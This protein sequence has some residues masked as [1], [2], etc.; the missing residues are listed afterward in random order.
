MTDQE[1]TPSPGIMSP[2]DVTAQAAAERADC[3]ATHPWFTKK[4]VTLPSAVFLLFVIIMV[5]TGGNDPRIFD[6]TTSAL[7]SKV[8]SATNFAPATATIGKSVRDGKLAF[9]VTSMQPP[10]KT[11]TDRFGTT[12][13]AEGVFVIVRVNATN[14]GYDPRTLTATDQFLV[15]DKGQRFAPSSAISSLAG[16]ETIFLEKINPGHTVNDAP[17]L[18]DVPSGTTIAGVELHDS[19]SSTGVTVKLS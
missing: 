10:S 12:K 6:F 14:I 15:N 5:G 18:F 9:I 4:R 3:T 16:A 1:T 7:E 11:L 13:T 2:E 19:L 8:E 17:L